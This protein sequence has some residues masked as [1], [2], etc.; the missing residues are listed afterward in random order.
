MSEIMARGLLTRALVIKPWPT[1]SHI[2]SPDNSTVKGIL[3]WISTLP[4][5]L[6]SKKKANKRKKKKRDTF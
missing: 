6:N 3:C 4:P 2:F 1:T 5:P